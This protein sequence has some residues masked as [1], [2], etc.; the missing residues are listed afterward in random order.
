MMPDNPLDDNHENVED[1]KNDSIPSYMYLMPQEELEKVKV[2]VIDGDKAGSKWLVL[3]DIQILYKYGYEGKNNA[4]SAGRIIVDLKWQL[5]QCSWLSVNQLSVYHTVILAFNVMQAKSP[6]YIH[7]MFNTNYSYKTRQA[8][9][10]MIRST[11]TPELDLAKDSFSW[12][13][14][15]LFNQLHIQG[16][17]LVP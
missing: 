1:P 7:T 17:C 4:Q 5:Q 6:K 15:D 14:A 3:D 11:R 16:G 10:G 12:R 2:E 9:S 13:A 8:D